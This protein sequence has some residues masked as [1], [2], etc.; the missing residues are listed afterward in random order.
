VTLLQKLQR[1][2]TS[3]QGKRALTEAQRLAKDPARRR[4]VDDLRRRL[5][6]GAKHDRAR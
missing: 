6:G 1:L 4:Q 2:A 5:A 3:P